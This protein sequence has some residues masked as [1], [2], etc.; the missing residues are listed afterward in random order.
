MS[1]SE[2][3][4]RNALLDIAHDFDNAMLVTHDLDGGLR[5]RPMAVG[6]LNNNG[7][8]WFITGRRSGKVEEIRAD[9]RVL[10]TMQGKTKQVSLTATAR[11]VDDRA[12]LESLWKKSWDVWFPDGPRSPNAVLL[13]VDASEGEYWDASG[14]QGLQF[15]FEAAKAF[16]KG[17][18]IDEGE[19]GDHGKARL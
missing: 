4:P 7:E 11:V 16:V 3:D 8:L 14:A 18:K 13:R 12:K 19:A 15:V 17:E 5:A 1:N 6:Q 10:V 2:K 9:D